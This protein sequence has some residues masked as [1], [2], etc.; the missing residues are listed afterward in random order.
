MMQSTIL[1]RGPEERKVTLYKNG[2]AF[3][4]TVEVL[5]SNFH[6]EVHTESLYTPETEPQ[7]DFLY[8]GAIRFL[9]GFQYEVVSECLL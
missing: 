7:A 5:A 9:Q 2:T 6:K 8:G 3:L 1:K 4:I